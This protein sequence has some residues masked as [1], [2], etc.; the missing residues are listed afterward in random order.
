LP[1]DTNSDAAPT[2]IA[3]AQLT[4]TITNGAVAV[5]LPPFSVTALTINT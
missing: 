5:T 1:L 4:P 2:T 3:P